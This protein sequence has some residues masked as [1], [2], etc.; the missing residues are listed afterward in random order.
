[1][2]QQE[3]ETACVQICA[4]ACVRIYNDTYE[5]ENGKI[6]DKINTLINDVETILHIPYNGDRTSIVEVTSFVLSNAWSLQQ[7]LRKRDM[8]LY[9]ADIVDVMDIY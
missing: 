5:P 4:Y 1:M 8:D 2:T 9:N 3:K 7:A 6:I